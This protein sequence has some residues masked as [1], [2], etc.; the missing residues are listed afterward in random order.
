M[1]ETEKYIRVVTI[2]RLIAQFQESTVNKYS[3]H[4]HQQI[5]NKIQNS[6]CGMRRLY[7]QQCVF[8][9]KYELN[10]IVT[11]IGYFEFYFM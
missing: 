2:D 10:K 5:T 1:Y 9:I 6:F 3:Y 8:L 7:R 11:K 4:K